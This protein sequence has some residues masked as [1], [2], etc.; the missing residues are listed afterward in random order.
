MPI[1]HANGID[2]HYEVAG[3]GTPLVFIHGLGSSARDWEYQ[4][5]EFS[6]S[7]QVVTFDLRG[8]GQSGKPEGPYQIPM[9]AA[10]AAGL[11][12]ALGLAP[13][14]VVGISLGGAVALQ[15]ALD[16]PEQVKTLTIVNSGPSMGGT[17]EQAQQEIERRAAI[18]QQLGMRGMG[19]ALSA[20]LFPQPE[21]AA[22]RATF[23]ERWADNDPR[24]YVEATRSVL[25]WDVTGRLA[26]VSCPTLIISADH[27]YT[28]V[29]AKEAYARLMPD[30]RVVVI[31]EARHATPVER[32][33]EFNAALAEFLAAHGG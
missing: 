3:T 10:D 32:P 27:D 2:Q 21:H 26:S 12:A 14:H 20:S 23:V 29:A 18:V 15:F 1:V 16:C 5:P 13:A 4:V 25:G 6:R 33:A 28:P 17:T 19:Q 7:Y 22:L 11:F 24:A 31:P 30:A 8:H 9:F